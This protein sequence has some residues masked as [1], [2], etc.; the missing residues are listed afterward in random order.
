[1]KRKNPANKTKPAITLTPR[2][3]RI[4]ETMLDKIELVQTTL[5]ADLAPPPPPD[6][7]RDCVQRSVGRWTNNL[8]ALWRLCA[9]PA[10]RRARRCR[11]LPMA[12]LAQRGTMPP[13][14]VLGGVRTMLV[15]RRHGPDYHD[16]RVGARDDVAAV[17]G[18][19]R[20]RW[21]RRAAVFGCARVSAAPSTSRS[22]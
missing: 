6:D 8:M 13:P 4:M 10:C 14:E 3:M 19:A 17:V 11:G 9:K 5:L 16:L 21:R 2:L 7:R 15:G 22:Q 20:A 18:L 1:M 12:C